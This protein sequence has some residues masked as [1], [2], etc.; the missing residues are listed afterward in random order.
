M[1]AANE[2]DLLIG[3][4]LRQRDDLPAAELLRLIA[5]IKADP[6]VGRRLK[7]ALLVDEAATRLLLPERTSF[8]AG[9]QQRLHPGQG[10]K[11]LARRVVR[12]ARRHRRTQVW[13]R[14]LL[15]TL[16]LAAVLMA[17]L[18][19]WPRA[20]PQAAP[21]P[22]A[23]VVAG[24]AQRSDGN[25][26]LRTGSILAE[27]DELSVREV[28]TIALADRSTLE[29]SPGSRLRIDS[30]G[31]SVRFRLSSGTVAAQI[32]HRDAAT[33]L[34]IATDEAVVTVVGTRFSVSQ[35][36]LG[37]RVA[38]R[39]GTVLIDDHQGAPVPLGAGGTRTIAT[40]LPLPTPLVRW[41]GDHA[42]DPGHD[43]HGHCPATAV[44]TVTV[45]SGTLVFAG[46]YLSAPPLQLSVK[47]GVTVTAWL[48]PTKP[49]A[50]WQCIVGGLKTGPGLKFGLAG[51]DTDRPGQA[52][53]DSHGIPG[54]A[55]TGRTRVDDEV[56]HHVAWVWQADGS[57]V[58]V[59]DGLAED[60][61]VCPGLAKVTWAGW[62][63]TVGAGDEQGRNGFRGRLDEVRIYDRALTTE[64][65]QA[66]M[67]Q[68]R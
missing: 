22:A 54:R 52:I 49:M 65:C 24:T 2:T 16:A 50:G 62:R 44:G 63:P 55:M 31:R 10:T 39:D 43:Q 4:F 66:V 53:F 48:N 28:V 17:G 7:D 1:S 64:Q 13:R 9:V 51:P 5:A 46:G 38:V 41:T 20:Q 60:Q 42:T 32:S 11:T 56:W 6:E 29:F 3:A 12:R 67:K 21:L 15:P 58:L 35:D 27:G 68:G 26:L 25:V 30:L 23:T 36:G 8:L 34:S 14:W 57:R 47:H 59:V 33:A 40:I 18:V 37:T 45:T 19:L 61:D